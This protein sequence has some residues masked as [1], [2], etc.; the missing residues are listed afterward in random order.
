MNRDIVIVSELR[1]AHS[2]LYSRLWRSHNKEARL[3]PSE[4]N[5]ICDVLTRTHEYIR[6][7]EGKGEPANE[8]WP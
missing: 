5:D 2:L 4:V 3:L 6:E 1:R 7:L 8:Q